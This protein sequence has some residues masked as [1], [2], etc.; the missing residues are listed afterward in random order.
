MAMEAV[1]TDPVRLTVFLHS[2]DCLGLSVSPIDSPEGSVFLRRRQVK[3]LKTEG[4]YVVIEV[5]RDLASRKK[6]I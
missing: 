6:L 5:S 1:G 4:F 2:E 3:V